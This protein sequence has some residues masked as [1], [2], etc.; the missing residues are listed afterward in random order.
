M[1]TIL[2]DTTNNNKQDN[3]TTITMQRTSVMNVHEERS[4]EKDQENRVWVVGENQPLPF[5]NKDEFQA[6]NPDD[7]LKQGSLYSLLI[8]TIIPRPIALI[9]TQSG[10]ESGKTLN[11]APFSY[12]NLMCHDPPLIAV[13]INTMGRQKLKKDTLV[14][15]EETGKQIYAL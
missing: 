6:F 2:P 4:L 10:E 1:S 7:L 5:P 12:F 14:N 8:S 9:T 3:K 11:C 15:I 13:G